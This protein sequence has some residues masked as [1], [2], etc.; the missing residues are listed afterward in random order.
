MSSLPPPGFTYAISVFPKTYN[1]IDSRLGTK[2]FIKYKFE[3]DAFKTR[4]ER[5]DGKLTAFDADY[6]D[7][8]VII[9]LTRQAYL[10]ME[11]YSIKGAF[12]HLFLMMKDGD[13]TDADLEQATARAMCMERLMHSSV[14]R[15]CDEFRF[16]TQENK[17]KEC[18]EFMK[19]LLGAAHSM[20]DSL[21]QQSEKP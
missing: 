14:P 2:R 21:K 8:R 9:K 6:P 15:I 11:V 4:I 17:L 7:G 10:D 5:R 3:G 19:V 1:E 12:I 16:M 20:V 13:F 18:A